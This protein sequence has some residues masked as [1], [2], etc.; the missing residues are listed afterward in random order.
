[1]ESLVQTTAEDSLQSWS[2]CPKLLKLRRHKNKG[3]TDPFLMA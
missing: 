3:Q 1:M 2:Q